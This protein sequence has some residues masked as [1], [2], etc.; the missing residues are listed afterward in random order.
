MDATTADPTVEIA[1][2]KREV[3][4]KDEALNALKAK[5]KAFV[6]NMRSQ[7]MNETQKST[8]LEVKLKETSAALFGPSVESNQQRWTEEIEMLKKEL[9][10]R[11]NEFK[12]REK[13]LADAMTLQL[14]CEKD[15]CRKLETQLQQTIEAL[16]VAEA[17]KASVDQFDFFSQPAVAAGSHTDVEFYAVQ[18]QL[19]SANFEVADLR[20]QL[21]NVESALQSAQQADSVR[22]ELETLRVASE[23]QCRQLQAEVNSLRARE[24]LLQTQLKAEDQRL[25]TGELAELKLKLEEHQRK[26]QHLQ[27]QLSDKEFQLKQLDSYRR[28]ADDSDTKVLQLQAEN[29][30]LQTKCHELPSSLCSKCIGLEEKLAEIS[31]LYEKVNLGRSRSDSLIAETQSQL[32]ELQTIKQQYV[33]SQ[34]RVDNLLKQNLTLNEKITEKEIQVTTLKTEMQKWS[35]EMAELKSQHNTLQSDNTQHRQR[36]ESVHADLQKVELTRNELQTK[37]AELEK[38]NKE[39][40]AAIESTHKDNNEKRQ[41]AKVLVQTLVSEKTGLLDARNHLQK[42][43]ERLRMEVNQRNV[44][45]EQQVKQLRDETNEKAAASLV[46]IQSLTDEVAYLKHALTTV[47]ESEKV[48][49]RAKELAAAKREIED[50]NKKRL[51]AKAETQKLAVELENV[52]KCLDHITTHVNANCTENI[53]QIAL[54]QGHVKEALDVLEKRA[55]VGGQ[56]KK[57]PEEVTATVVRKAEAFSGVRSGNQLQS[58]EAKR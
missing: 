50:S 30:L 37:C 43:V 18:S 41:K 48:Q 57:T 3:H 7:L 15:R 4:A 32:G 46:T 1:R 31:Q 51:A 58:P 13:S 33:A 35:M 20:E 49:Q 17:T 24:N 26:N 11:E 29:S 34:E 2:L 23:Q 21:R 6:D 45:N 38:K 47:Q 9:S 12:S 27:G 53:Q 16:R 44:D 54:L 55:G 40:T 5:T 10:A 14:E 52:H 8:A 56:P 25:D 19:S 28:R 39:L 42:E 22:D 36:S